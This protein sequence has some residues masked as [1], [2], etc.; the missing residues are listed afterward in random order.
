[1]SQQTQGIQVWCHFNSGSY[2]ALSVVE[3]KEDDCFSPKSSGLG[4][5]PSD[6]NINALHLFD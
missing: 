6:E 1:M 4:P 5:E 2:N 3:I